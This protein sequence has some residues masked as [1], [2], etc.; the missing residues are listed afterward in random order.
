MVHSPEHSFV[1]TRNITKKIY[2]ATPVARKMAKL[3]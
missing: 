2:G 1:G 3:A